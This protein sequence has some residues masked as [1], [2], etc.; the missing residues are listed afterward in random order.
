[1]TIG[2]D[3]EQALIVAAAGWPLHPGQS[4]FDLLTG[5]R[6]KVT[7]LPIMVKWHWVRGHQ[8]DLTT[9][10]LDEWAKT[11]IYVD[12]MAKAYWN[13]LN[14]RDFAPTP[15]HFGDEGWSISLRN[16][17]M[18]RLNKQALYETL[19]GP[20][21]KTYCKTH[22]DLNHEDI[23][24]IDEELIG[25]AFKALTGAKKRRMTKHATGHFGCGA[26]MQ[27]WK[28]QDHCECPRCPSNM[29][30]RCT[31]SIA[32]HLQHACVWKR[33]LRSLMNG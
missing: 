32:R 16:W 8:D 4:D 6:A 9:G 11:N 30:H 18:S 31:S 12:N 29:R 21:T 2:L 22:G 10:S 20:E 24:D 15:Q 5:I 19:V 33:P 28:F 23:L 27:M 17:K 7:R 26:K 14:R 1:M 3:G 13:Y 25:K